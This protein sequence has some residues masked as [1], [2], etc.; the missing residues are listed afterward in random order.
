MLRRAP[1]LI[2]IVLIV[3]IAGGCT[4]TE[5]EDPAEVAFGEFR[6]ALRNAETTD[7]KATLAENFLAEFPNT[8]HS[9]WM[10][11]VIVY[12]RGHELDDPEAA[13]TVLSEALDHIEDPEQRFEVSMQALSLSD[14][15]ELPLNVGKVAEAFGA[16]RTLDFDQ[17]IWVAETAID[18]EEWGVADEH[19]AAALELA[20]PE[21]YR[22]EDPDSEYTDDEVAKNVRNRKALALASNGWAV[23][24][25][26]KSDLAFT[27]FEAANEAGS[28]GYMGVPNPPLFKN[29]GRAALREGDLDRAIELLGAET[30]YGEE[31]PAT[32]PYLRE[33][34]VAKNG[35]DTGFDEFLWATRSQLATDVDDFELLD[36]EGNPVSFSSRADGKVTLLAFWFPT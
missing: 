7:E 12:Y 24:N 19:S 1:A 34:Y 26:G 14:S 33:A 27:Q 35:D 23:Y 13:W 30:L 11:S 9:G 2:L 29:W 3:G 17:H 5:Q 32:K 15:V 21:I 10:A 20:T 28:V 4:Q 31:G 22:A 6:T 36:Y 16:V 8:E 18:L 25:L